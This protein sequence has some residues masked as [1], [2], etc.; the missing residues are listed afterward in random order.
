MMNIKISKRALV[1]TISYSTAALLL[2]IGYAARQNAIAR[3]YRIQIEILYP[4]PRELSSYLTNLSV[5]L[6]KGQYVGTPI[7]CPVIRSHLAGKR[8]G[9]IGAFHPSR[10]RLNMENTINF[11]RRLATMP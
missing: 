1:R 10:K 7:A 3:D 8:R 6:D 4:L 5:D 2:C 9:K 11:S